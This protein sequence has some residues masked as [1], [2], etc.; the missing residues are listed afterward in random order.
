MWPSTSMPS[1]IL[2]YILATLL[3]VLVLHVAS[4]ALRLPLT[5]SHLDSSTGR[6]SLRDR[7]PFGSASTLV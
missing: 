6:V 2:K 5:V 4:D 3:L 1:F 7:P